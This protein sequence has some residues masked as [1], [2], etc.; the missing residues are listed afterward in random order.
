[1]T[2]KSTVSTDDLDQLK[3]DSQNIMA[4][5]FQFDSKSLQSTINGLVAAVAGGGDTT[6]AQTDF[7]ALFSGSNVDQATIDRTFTDLVQ[8]I[9]DS[10]ITAADASLIAADQAAVQA[11][12]AALPQGGM[13]GNNQGGGML[14]G[15]GGMGGG[16]RGRHGPRRPRH[17]RRDDIRRRDVRRP[18]RH[19]RGHDWTDQP[20]R[21]RLGFRPD[22]GVERESRL[23]G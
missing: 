16:P 6:Q 10:N 18:R 17:G 12:L 21:R 22:H 5:G 23:D 19:G 8:T 1:M 2:A 4:A 11:D 13:P 9:Q 7:N 14:G 20:G 3:T 15:P